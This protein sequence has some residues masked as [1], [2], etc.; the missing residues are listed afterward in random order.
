MKLHCEEALRLRFRCAILAG[1][2]RGGLRHLPISR[3]RHHANGYGWIG[4]RYC[5]SANIVA[6]LPNLSWQPTILLGSTCPL[7]LLSVAAKFEA[8]IRSFMQDRNLKSFPG[9]ATWNGW[10]G[11]VCSSAWPISKWSGIIISNQ[12]IGLLQDKLYKKQNGIPTGPMVVFYGCRHEQDSVIWLVYIECSSS[13][14]PLCMLPISVC[15][16]FHRTP[17]WCQLVRV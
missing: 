9:L 6:V 2:L 7:R 16:E 14:L 3:E 5:G 13:F 15:K 10:R 12:V 1:C 17:S 8:P 4:N 11:H